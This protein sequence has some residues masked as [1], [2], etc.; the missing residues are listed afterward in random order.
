MLLS[1]TPTKETEVKIVEKHLSFPVKDHSPVAAAKMQFYNQ[2]N[3]RLSVGLRVIVETMR[4]GFW[5]PVASTDRLIML[6]PGKMAEVKLNLLWPRVPGQR[7]R[8][9][10][11][12][13]TGGTLEVKEANVYKL[14]H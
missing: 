6:M 3:K 14:S 11:P 12:S 4:H 1:Q 8:V 9:R 2:G 5:I 13:A 10:W 7:N